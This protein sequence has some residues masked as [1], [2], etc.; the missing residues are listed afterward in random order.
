[1]SIAELISSYCDR[2]LRAGGEKL[3]DEAIEEALEAVVQLFGYIQNKV[4]VCALARL[5]GAASL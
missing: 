4:C 1:M 2:V 3:S 5:L